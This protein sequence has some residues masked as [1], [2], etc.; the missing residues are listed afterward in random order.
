M[1]TRNSSVFVVITVII[2]ILSCSPPVKNATE[3]VGE[4]PV[5][6]TVQFSDGCN[7][8]TDKLISYGL[9]LVHHM[10]FE[11]AET[12]FTKIIESEPDCFWGPW[13]KALTRI[14]PL[15]NDP[16][17]EENMK[18]GWDMS[19][20]AL[21]LAKNE[22]E[23]RYGNALA[24]YYENGLQKTETERLKN[25]YEGWKNAYEAN[26]K[27]LEAK[28]F[29]ALTLIATADPTDQ[30]F[31]NQLKAGALAEEVMQ[32]INDHPGAFHYIIHA[33][34]VPGLSEKALA[35]ANTYGKIAPEIPHALHMPSHIFTRL[36]MWTESLDWNKRSAAIAFS[37]P[38]QDGISKNYFHALDYMMY[39]HLQLG[40][41]D[42]ATAILQDIKKLNSPYQAH[43]ATAYTLA[44]IESR[45]YLERQDWKHASEL[46]LTTNAGFNWD[47]FP[48]YEALSHF[49]AGLG[50]AR[51]GADKE[52]QNQLRRLDTLQTLIKNPYWAG[53]VEIQ[54]NIIRGWLALKRGSK[55]E[56]IDLMKLASE[57]EWATQKHPI[58]PGELLPARELYGDLLLELNRS[59][60]ALEQYEMSL[61]RSPGRLNSVYG[62]AR[63]AQLSG[64]A[65]K[66]KLYYQQFLDL[67]SGANGMLDK[68]QKSIAFL[69]TS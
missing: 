6:G 63:S 69:G 40:E 52:V 57:Q 62:A 26:T 19:Q 3:L 10:T 44:A 22:K 46:S 11:E 29:Y 50:F 68:R 9:A 7:Q 17:G 59:K 36:G 8:E 65:Q 1:T 38:G 18:A 35:V 5:C 55:K 47:K 54:K 25:Y 15:W 23:I 39:A 58:T 27:D 31:S 66:A 33:Y 64:D 4:I 16:P 45:F 34:D 43:P 60:E 28:T 67:T 2:A 12:V 30:S 49:A 13:G 61:Q 37:K 32:E 42:K 24:S 51:L 41:D 56:A 21:K 53:Q 20:Q 14:H 48:E